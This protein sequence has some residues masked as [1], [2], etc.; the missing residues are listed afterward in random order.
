MVPSLP[1][2]L[3]VLDTR[4]LSRMELRVN[5]HSLEPIAVVPEE[6]FATT[7]AT[8]AA[9]TTGRAESGIVVFRRR[10]VSDGMRERV[11]ITNYGINRA[12]L[13]LE[14]LF[15][16]DFAD[17][18]E[19]K[20]ARAH[21]VPAQ[22]RVEDQ[23]LVFEQRES[24]SGRRRATLY[25]D[26][27]P[28]L[29]GGRARWDVVLEPDASWEVCIQLTVAVD[30]APLA[31]RFRC[32]QRDDTQS[33]PERRM[34]SWR[35]RLSSIS[36]DHAAFARSIA[37]AGEDLGAL[38][39]FDP[40][41]PEL[42][43]IAAGAPWFM[44]VFGRDSLL[45][46]WMTLIVGSFTRDRS[47]RDPG[48]VP[49]RRGQPDDGRGAGQDPARDPFRHCRRAGPRWW[50]HLL[51]HGGRDAAVRD[52]AGRGPSMGSRRRSSSNVSFPSADKA[53]GWIEHFGDRDG[54]GYVEYQRR[55]GRRPRE[56]G[57]EGLVG[58]DA[59]RRR[60]A[61]AASDRAVRGPGLCVRRVPR[62][63]PTSPAR[64]ATKPDRDLY[65]DKANALRR[66]FNED[67][68]LEDEGTFAVGLDA[69]QAADRRGDI[70]C[71]ALPVDGIVDDE[72]ARVGRRPAH[73]RRH[74]HRMGHTH[75]GDVDGRV[76]P[77]QLPQRLACGRTT[78]PSAL[79][80][81]RAMDSSNTRTRSSKANSPHPLCT[82]DGCPSCSRGSR[83][84]SSRCRRV[85]RVVL[86]AGVGIG[87]ATVVA[88]D[89]A[90]PVSERA[91]RRALGGA[92]T[93]GV[94]PEVDGGTDPARRRAGR[95]RCRS[96]RRE[97][98]DLRPRI[99]D[100]SRAST[101]FEPLHRRGLG[102]VER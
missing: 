45:T 49:G 94:D 99:R 88:S 18:F 8:R 44:T 98:D 59:L 63:A 67:F 30:G 31:P 40:S 76:Q 21:R 65:L 27:P 9:T 89:A 36:T 80:G 96:G 13:V 83:S 17:L 20:E 41:H 48:S 73:T 39:I 12:S 55:T 34:A 38:R 4:V 77:C 6:P 56:P 75:T 53:L 35:A 72:R 5:E 37:S 52:A 81:S 57:L 90:T 29:E 14:V 62:A 71:R 100:H 69:R 10:H 46:A 91:A 86:S 16:A 79:P 78:T 68:W 97:R 3:F 2:G 47:P 85:S 87:V 66:R 43:I 42:A 102:Q 22:P 23:C 95:H 33:L 32:D 101:R 11:A 51:R 7:F 60:H 70:Q 1:Q 26:R 54:D 15:G 93:A 24:E 82:T 64:P 61:R 25:F 58:R 19:V 84:S 28:S 92:R 74:V 50:S